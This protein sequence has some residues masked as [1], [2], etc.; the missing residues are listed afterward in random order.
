MSGLTARLDELGPALSAKERAILVLRSFK[1]KTP[2]NPMW[3]RTMPKSQYAEFN[4]LID[5]M[6]ACDL[7]L[8]DLI[9]G[10]LLLVQQ[11]EA[12][13]G[14]LLSTNLY[15]SA[16][17]RMAL[18]I[19]TSTREPVTESDYR[20]RQRAEG[21]IFKNVRELAEWLADACEELGEGNLVADTNAD[22]AVIKHGALKRVVEVKERE[23]RLA[24]EQGKL[25]TKLRGHRLFVEQ[26][27][28]FAWCGL[29]VPF[30]PEFATEYE[31]RPDAAAS[32]VASSR[33][34]RIE[35]FKDLERYTGV[36]GG[37]PLLEADDRIGD[38]AGMIDALHERLRAEMQ[39]RW[40]ELRAVEIVA[41]ELALEFDGEDPLRPIHRAD[42]DEAKTIL[43]GMQEPL[44]LCLGGTIM[45]PE[46]D[47]DSVEETRS[48]LEI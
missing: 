39:Q 23:I 13:L 26:R 46:P 29:E 19:W 2:E 11:L 44:G 34:A 15:R 25:K 17:E 36:F 42:L 28:F 48:L 27:S 22:A 7:N 21:D 35:I 16:L 20:A 31:V 38:I 9:T 6:N 3:R 30:Y 8:G 5:L 14:C 41:A 12:R 32:E 33:A 18:H 10:S 43:Q 47:E 4:R 1:D 24:A 40:R 37:H 45:L